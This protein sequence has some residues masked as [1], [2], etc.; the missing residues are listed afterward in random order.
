MLYLA[1]HR[2]FWFSETV[3]VNGGKK[4]L[5]NENGKTQ[6][7]IIFPETISWLFQIIHRPLCVVSEVTGTLFLGNSNTKLLLRLLDV[8][9][10]CWSTTNKIKFSFIALWWQQNS[11]KAKISKP[12][13]MK[14]VNLGLY[15]VRG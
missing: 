4:L 14:W 12:Q 3:D 13:K 5:K 10:Q 15:D 11:E 8:I 9:F 1:T 2:Q 7:K 6:G